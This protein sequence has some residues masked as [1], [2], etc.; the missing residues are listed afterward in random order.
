ML[1]FFDC[2]RK[3]EIF[4][5]NCYSSIGNFGSIIYYLQFPF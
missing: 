5:W 3:I 1:K 4:H 2:D